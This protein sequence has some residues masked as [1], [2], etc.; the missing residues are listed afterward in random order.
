MDIKKL[1]ATPENNPFPDGNFP[2]EADNKLA[3]RYQDIFKQFIKHHASIDRVTFWGVTDGDSWL[4]GWPV[5]GRT[6]YP[7]L[8]NRDGSAKKAHDKVV[9]LAK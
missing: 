1:Q 7:L 6:N 2:A 9:E 8:F 5:V 3:S 4:N